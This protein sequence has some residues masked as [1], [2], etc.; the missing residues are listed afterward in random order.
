MIELFSINDTVIAII[1]SLLSL[2]LCIRSAH[3]KKI[4]EQRTIAIKRSEKNLE[5]ALD[6]LAQLEENEKIAADFRNTL[7][8]AEMSTKIQTPRLQFNS[9]NHKP[10]IPDKYRYIHGLSQKGVDPEDIASILNISNNE[11]EQLVNL[12]NLS[13]NST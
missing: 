13:P 12:A 8:T 9:S 11:A 1:A 7:E 6:R 10:V 5:D 4:V 2:F 3:L